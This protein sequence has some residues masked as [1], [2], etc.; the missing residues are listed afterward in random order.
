MINQR[1]LCKSWKAQ[2]NGPLALTLTRHRHSWMLIN[3]IGDMSFW[4]CIKCQKDEAL[5]KGDS[6][7]EYD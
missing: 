6:L 3:R 5:G 4:R 1:Y 7:Y 2:V